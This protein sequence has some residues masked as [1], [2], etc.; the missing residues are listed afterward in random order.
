MCGAVL[1][2]CSAP[3]RVALKAPGLKAENSPTVLLPKGV[4]DVQ[5]NVQAVNEEPGVSRVDPH[6]VAQTLENRGSPLSWGDYS[7]LT[8]L[9]QGQKSIKLN[10]GLNVSNI[11]HMQQTSC[12]ICN[13]NLMLLQKWQKS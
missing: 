10:F 4:V 13:Q 9:Y 11:K 7:A 2:F 12:S 6:G 1:W 5:I 8:W 3:P